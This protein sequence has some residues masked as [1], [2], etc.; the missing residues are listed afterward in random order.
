MY[1]FDLGVVPWLTIVQRYTIETEFH[2]IS[3]VKTG[4]DVQISLGDYEELYG[5]GD[6]I[7]DTE[8]SVDF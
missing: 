8:S 2:T 7:V 6:L 4:T 1:A 5:H 3:G